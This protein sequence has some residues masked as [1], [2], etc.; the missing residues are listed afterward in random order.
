MKANNNQGMHGSSF[1][2]YANNNN[3]AGHR[4]EVSEGIQSGDLKGTS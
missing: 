1:H 2:G 4:D 3:S